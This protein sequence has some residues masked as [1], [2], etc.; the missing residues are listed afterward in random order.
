MN[1]KR[2][3]VLAAILALL[4]AGIVR[5]EALQNVLG[6]F[7]CIVMEPDFQTF[8]SFVPYDSLTDTLLRYIRGYQKTSLTR[9]SYPR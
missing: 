9:W 8:D 3:F 4:L 2:Q 5:L 6:E 1:F 7:F